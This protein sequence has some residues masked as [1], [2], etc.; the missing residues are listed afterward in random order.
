MYNHCLYVD[1]F[2]SSFL[3]GGTEVRDNMGEDGR[4]LS[5]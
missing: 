3:V 4:F 5:N 1:N 2:V